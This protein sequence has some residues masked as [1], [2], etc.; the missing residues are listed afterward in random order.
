VTL[1]WDPQLGQPQDL[2]NI[3]A[4]TNLANARMMDFL[5]SLD[6]KKVLSLLE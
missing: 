1:G 2:G 4:A 5:R 6:W 3:P